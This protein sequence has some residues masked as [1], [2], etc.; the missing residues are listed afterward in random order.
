MKKIATVV[1]SLGL[2][3][4]LSSMASATTNF[5][6]T[7]WVPAPGY[8]PEC[9]FSATGPWGSDVLSGTGAK[10]SAPSGCGVDNGRPASWLSNRMY[11]QNGNSLLA[12][13][14]ETYNGSGQSQTYRF[15]GRYPG[16]NRVCGNATYYQSTLSYIAVAPYQCTPF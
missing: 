13:F 5:F 7:D 2:V 4:T 8:P 11:Q 3:W 15:A 9:A 16:A 12:V 1:L 10:I 6:I 14:P